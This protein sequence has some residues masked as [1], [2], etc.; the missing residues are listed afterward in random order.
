LLAQIVGMATLFGFALP[1]AWALNSLLNLGMRQRA[2]A[3]GEYQGMDLS[4]L[5]SGAYPEFMTHSDDFMPR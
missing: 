4:E 1:A 5:G 2:S 3:E